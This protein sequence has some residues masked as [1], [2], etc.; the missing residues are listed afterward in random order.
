MA[1]ILPIFHLEVISCL[2]FLV[3]Y[4][5]DQYKTEYEAK[6]RDE[7]EQIRVRTNAEID[8]LKT[9]TRELFERENRYPNVDF[10]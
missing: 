5:R 9:S 10:P 3:F 6:L 2:T 1:R 8:R 4:Y 7:L